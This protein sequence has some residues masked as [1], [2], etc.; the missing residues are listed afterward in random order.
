MAL[1]TALIRPGAA[2]CFFRCA[3][4]ETAIGLGSDGILTDQHPAIPIVRAQARGKRW[5][6]DSPAFESPQLLPPRTEFAFD[7]IANHGHFKVILYDPTL[8]PLP[9]LPTI[10]LSIGNLS[11]TRAIYAPC[12]IGADPSNHFALRFPGIGDHHLTLTP[13]PRLLSISRQSGVHIS[14]AGQAISLRLGWWRFPATVTL[15]S[16]WDLEINDF[17]QAERAEPPESASFSLA[18]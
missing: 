4:L 18:A 1:F 12:A 7:I 16:T 6:I 8:A 2:P 9:N 15:P 3:S 17:E 14:R 11:I 13:S 10:S 5:L